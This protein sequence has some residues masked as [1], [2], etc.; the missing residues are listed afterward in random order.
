M[1]KILAKR[2]VYGLLIIFLL[3]CA[4][5]ETESERAR[6]VRLLSNNANKNWILKEKFVGDA[7]HVL[8][9]C[10]SSYVLSI[11]ADYTWEEV[12]LKL[13]CYN[14]SSGT[15]S[16]NNEN[17]VLSIAFISQYTGNESKRDFEINELT[18]QNF[19]YQYVE[20]N[21]IKRVILM[22]LPE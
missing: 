17:A 16:L 3:G 2:W 7:T 15:W 19:A 5:K 11:K 18:E 13:I 6:A 10:D 9:I 21:Q 8:S 22:A 14:K 4:G 20:Y 1:N 12:Y